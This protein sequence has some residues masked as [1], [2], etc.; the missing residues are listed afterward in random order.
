MEKPEIPSRRKKEK[1]A[2]KRK[3]SRKRKNDAKRPAKIETL[4]KKECTDMYTSPIGRE[5]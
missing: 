4:K 1:A 5:E 3:R 2:A